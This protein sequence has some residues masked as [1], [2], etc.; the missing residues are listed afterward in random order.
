MPTW[1]DVQRKIATGD[2]SGA[3][4]AVYDA[5]KA[6]DKGDLPG[7]I[8]GLKTEDA[9]TL[10]ILFTKVPSP[11]PRHAWGVSLKNLTER[12][13]KEGEWSLIAALK[14]AFSKIVEDWND[15]VFT[16]VLQFSAR[17]LYIERNDKSKAELIGNACDSLLSVQ[18]VA[19]A[20][21]LPCSEEKLC[22]C[23]TIDF[24]A[25]V[26]NFPLYVE[27]RRAGARIDYFYS[28]LSDEAGHIS[29]QG[30][31]LSFAVAGKKWEM[32]KA[33]CE[34]AEWGADCFSQFGEIVAA[35]A[36]DLPNPA[37]KE[38]ILSL[39]KRAVDKSLGLWKDVTNAHYQVVIKVLV[40]KNEADLL[41]AFL[42][43]GVRADQCAGALKSSLGFLETKDAV[44]YE[45]VST[46]VLGMVEKLVQRTIWKVMDKH[47]LTDL[48]EKSVITLRV[49]VG[50]TLSQGL[51][52]FEDNTT[53]GRIKNRILC[54][55]SQQWDQA[56]VLAGDAIS[57]LPQSELTVRTAGDVAV[58]ISQAFFDLLKV[59]SVAV[60]LERFVGRLIAERRA[61]INEQQP[62][63]IVAKAQR[64]LASLVMAIVF[65]QERVSQSAVQDI[66]LFLPGVLN[67]VQPA[68]ALTLPSKKSVEADAKLANEVLFGKVAMIVI[69]AVVRLEVQKSG[70]CHPKLA[71]VAARTML[72]KINDSAGLHCESN[73][74]AWLGVGV[75]NLDPSL[76][77]QLDCRVA[78]MFAQPEVEKRKPEADEFAWVAEAL[79]PE[80]V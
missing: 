49:E 60:V 38:L 76:K 63:N 7:I 64:Q 72:N 69:D 58:T 1:G 36:K 3:I 24:F 52:H 65:Y 30:R 11:S 66:V 77:A 9:G 78:G 47:E 33:V 74:E 43:L 34:S 10:R 15:R 28:W 46:L 4:V 23:N 16:S 25:A 68:A 70:F 71:I 40:E 62:E 51:G 55:F 32:L 26:G 37:A 44:Q 48:T 67:A 12:L 75:A 2:Y 57:Q 41:K 17:Q 14:P 8:A 59:P 61:L 19:L 31:T 50:K 20:S 42:A 56:R 54:E 27:A 73:L 29:V 21:C 53:A 22:Y 45:G 80:V 18:G 5:V 79:K 35:A 39:F 6:S 13:V